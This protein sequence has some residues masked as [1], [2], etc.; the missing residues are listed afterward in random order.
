M[1]LTAWSSVIEK[2]TRNSDDEIV[3]DRVKEASKLQ[4]CQEKKHISIRFI[5]EI[6][7]K[8]I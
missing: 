5:K 1:N 2:T 3:S 7:K 4:I 6:K 8:C